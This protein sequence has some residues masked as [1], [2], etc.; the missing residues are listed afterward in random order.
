MLLWGRFVWGLA[1]SPVQ[2]E[3]GSAALSSVP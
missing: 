3:Q 1:L 2:T